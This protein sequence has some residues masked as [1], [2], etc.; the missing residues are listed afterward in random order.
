MRRQQRWTVR[1]ALAR[2]GANSRCT[3]ERRRLRKRSRW[4][5][6]LRYFSVHRNQDRFIPS[7]GG[8]AIRSGPLFLCMASA[9]TKG[10]GV[11]GDVRHGVVRS[12][13]FP[14]RRAAPPTI[15]ANRPPPPR[16][17][18]HPALPALPASNFRAYHQFSQS[19]S[20]PPNQHPIRTWSMRGAGRGLDQALC[21]QVNRGR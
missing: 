7:K 18:P 20:P 9:A 16:N 8:P 10:V 5:W 14:A 2:G 6:S 1:E 4:R 17:P 3:G 13:T 21:A 19:C 15:C 12:P 11:V